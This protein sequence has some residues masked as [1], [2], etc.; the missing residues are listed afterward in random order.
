MNIKVNKITGETEEY[1]V[2]TAFGLNDKNYVV[3]ESKMKDSNGYDIVYI[4]RVVDNSLEVIDYRNSEEEVEWK[5]VKKNLIDIIKN[6]SEQKY[7]TPEV[8]Y[9][10]K[11]FLGQT[12]SLKEEHLEPLISEYDNYLKAKEEVAAPVEEIQTEEVVVETPE[13]EIVPVEEVIAPVEEVVEAPTEEVVTVEEPVIEETQ[14]VENEVSNEI[15]EVSIGDF[16]I[17]DENTNEVVEPVIEPAIEIVDVKEPSIDIVSEITAN[18]EIDESFAPA[19][20]IVNYEEEK[21]PVINENEITEIGN[22]FVNIEPV[23]E[24]EIITPIVEDTEEV[25]TPVEEVVEEIAPVKENTD[26]ENALENLKNILENMKKELDEREQNIASKEK[27]LSER[28]A[29]VTIRENTVLEKEKNII[30]IQAKLTEQ[31]QGL[32][33]VDN[34]EDFQ[35]TI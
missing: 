12:L 9:S 16:V 1:K 8:E 4:S 14:E 3:L 31:N 29:N 21:E 17:G 13:E 2:Y 26:L 32:M 18:N 10:G 7:F 24:E 30:E 20:E 22:E 25:I 19:I 11:E 5:E 23:I 27:E 34:T 6:K 35:R 15:E 28:E 33:T